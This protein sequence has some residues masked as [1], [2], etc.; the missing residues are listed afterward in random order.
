M[1]VERRADAHERPIEL[2]AVCIRPTFLARAAQPDEHQLR[3]R[4]D[5]VVDLVR[6]LQRRSAVGMAERTSPRC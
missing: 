1:E 3:I 2:Q 6:R 4:G 5:D